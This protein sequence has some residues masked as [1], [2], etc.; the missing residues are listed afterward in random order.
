MGS[1]LN[2]SE[3]YNVKSWL[4]PENAKHNIWCFNFYFPTPKLISKI[5]FQS[6]F[7]SS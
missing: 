7:F 3:D 4:F 6:S 5:G 1:E 2:G